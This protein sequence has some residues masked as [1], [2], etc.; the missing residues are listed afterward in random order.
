MTKPVQTTTFT[1]FAALHEPVT[2]EDI[3]AYQKT[4]TRKVSRMQWVMVSLVPIVLLFIMA[5]ILTRLAIASSWPVYI[6]IVLIVLAIGYIIERR[7][8]RYLARLYKL[9]LQNNATLVADEPHPPHNGLIF[10]HGH[11]RMQQEAF[12]FPNGIEI[13]NYQYFT[14]SGRQTRQ[15]EWGYAVIPLLRTVPHMLLDAKANNAGWFSSLPSGLKASTK[16]RLEG[17]FNKH[18]TLRVHK[19]QERDALYILTPDVMEDLIDKASGYDIELRDTTLFLYHQDFFNLT[20]ESAL[21]DIAD[22][23]TVLLPELHQQTKRLKNKE[24]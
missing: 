6:A 13:G 10:Q 21:R 24:E 15:W 12:T 5:G 4:V 11:H 14:G 17:N 9:A 2:A 7:R 19:K 3:R 20:N 22:I 23:I 18:F 8:L 16:L 1:N